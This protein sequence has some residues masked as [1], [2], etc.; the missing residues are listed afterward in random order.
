MM[1]V[2]LCVVNYFVYP[3]NKMQNY[4]KFFTL[5]KNIHFLL[6]IL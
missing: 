6:D 4:I 2:Y 3:Q 5:R 1:F